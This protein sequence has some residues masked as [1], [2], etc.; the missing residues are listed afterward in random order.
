MNWTPERIK[1]LRA[2]TGHTQQSLATTLGISIETVR[3]WEQSRKKPSALASR[4]LSDWSG[5]LPVKAGGV[6]A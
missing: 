2:E 4:A 1:H 3:A 6:A 5:K